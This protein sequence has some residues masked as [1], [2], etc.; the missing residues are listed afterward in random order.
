MW[1]LNRQTVPHYG[2]QEPTKSRV[3]QKQGPMQHF[4]GQKKLEA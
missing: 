1:Y 2:S 3:H 4:S